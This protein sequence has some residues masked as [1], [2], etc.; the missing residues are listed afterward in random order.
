MTTSTAAKITCPDCGAQC[1]TERGLK[2]HQTR[3]HPTVDANEIFERMGRA[4]EVLFPQGIPASR[5]I[6]VAE[7]QKV[8]LK[9]IT[10]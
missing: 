5:V 6:E 2:A 9:V 10:R 1:A 4:T 3:T 7:M 8:I